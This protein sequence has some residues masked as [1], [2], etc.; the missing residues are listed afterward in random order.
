MAIFFALLLILVLLACWA[1]TLMGMPGNWLMVAATAVYALT[2]SNCKRLGK[3][4]AHG[5]GRVGV[6]A[7]V[8]NSR[9]RSGVE[10]LWRPE[11]SRLHAGMVAEAV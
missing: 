4:A 10:P 2:R 1:F 6:V 8:Y 9:R 11:V 5:P 3:L 7:Q